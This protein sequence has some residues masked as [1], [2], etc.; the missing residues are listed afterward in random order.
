MEIIKAFE[1]NKL[2]IQINIKGTHENPL[3]RASDIGLILGHTNIHATIKDY[4]NSEKV[5]SN[6]E[7]KGGPQNVTFLTVKGLKKIICK[8]R[9]PIGIE[10]AKK[11]GID[12]YDIMHVPLE[13]SLV[14]FL[15]EVYKNEKII[16][17]YSVGPYR[18]DL[19]FPDYNLGVECDEYF[20][21]FQK[22][23]DIKRELYIKEKLKCEFVR[24]S[25][26]KK[27]KHL[28]QLICKINKIIENTKLNKLRYEIMR[29]NTK[30]D[31]YDYKEE[32][33]FDYIGEYGLREAGYE[34]PE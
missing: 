3:F 28:P 1:N 16:L 5:V 7:T 12:V 13:T 8:T 23:D 9:K 17:Q 15:Q 11:L 34:I 4:D 31:I 18:I 2:D 25:H 6:V 27:N 19:Y 24:F 33:I 22:E 14:H 30:L 32:Y 10:L 29:L 26:D 20:H 21:I